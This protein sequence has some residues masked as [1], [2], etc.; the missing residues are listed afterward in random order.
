[1]KINII[2]SADEKIR[3]KVRYGFTLL[4]APVRAEIE[5]SRTI[6]PGCPN[7]FYGHQLP[8]DSKKVFWIRSSADFLKCISNSVLPDIS[9]L[10]FLEYAGKRLPKLFAC[11]NPLNSSLDFDIVAATF[12]LASEFQDIIG[13]ERDE[14][15]RMR[16]MDSLQYKLGVLGFPVVNYYSRLLKEEM[17]R[18]FGIQIES[19][20]Y[21]GSSC[22]IALTH[23]VDFIT[24][25]SMRMIRREMFG[26]ALLNRHMLGSTQR[27]SKLLFPL[28][29]LFGYDYP[30]MG[31]HFLRNTEE[32][33]SVTSTFFIKTGATGKQ[34]IP[35]NYRSRGMRSFMKSVSDSG[36][37]I[38][39]HPSMSTYVSVD[40]F[41]R[42]KNRLQ[43]VLGRPVRSVRQHYLRFAAGRTIEIWEKA[44]MKHD[45]T[46]GFS[47]EVGFRNSIAFPYPLFNFT[48]DRVS[49][50]TELP[51]MLMDGTL[52]ENKTISSEQA[53]ERMKDLVRETKSANGAA[54]ILFHNSITDPIDFPGYTEIYPELVREIRSSGF[55]A[56]TL[57]GTIENFR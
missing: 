10:P 33:N 24:F 3:E 32:S 25:L 37:E 8:D 17:E 44:G 46:L 54:A 50:V 19:R 35:Y 22:A 23:D 41:V 34:D 39:I 20:T 27:M 15:D 38:G 28:F 14:F 36:F 7:I 42:E 4:F 30:K 57:A 13:L 56:G 43:D 52:S 45:S 49:D 40:D 11:A 6:V 55:S 53:H 26:I 51:L 21:S 2:I 16:A 31:L 18:Y 12:I 47:R 48:E 29:A 5:F 1:M 9:S